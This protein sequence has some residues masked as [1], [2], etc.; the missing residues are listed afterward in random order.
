VKILYLKAGHPDTKLKY[1]DDT[2]SRHYGFPEYVSVAQ[3]RAEAARK[4][5]AL[6]KEK[7]NIQPVLIK[8]RSIAHT[9]WGKSWNQNLERYA[10]YSN[11][12]ERGRSY[13]RHGA[14]LDLQIKPGKI[15]ALVQGSRTRP[16]EVV[17]SIVSLNKAN[18]KR[19]KETTEGQLDSLSE[20]L[21][22][23]FPKPLQE[24]FF[25]EK[26]G[27]FPRPR[28]I[29]F[30]CSCPD[31]ASMCKHVA[32]SLYGVGARL[33][34]DPSL[35]FKLRR[36]K[37]DDLITQ[38]VKSTGQALLKKAE[39][40]SS[41]VLEDTDLTDVFGIKLD[42][43]VDLVQRPSRR[44]AKAKKKI[45]GGRQ[46]QASSVNPSKGKAARSS[47]KTRNKA[48]GKSPSKSIKTPVAPKKSPANPTKTQ[49]IPTKV[50]TSTITDSVVA[51][52]PKRRKTMRVADICAR[53]GLSEQQ[54]RNAVARAIVQG[55]LRKTGRGIY[56]RP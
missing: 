4:L 12:I 27:L 21:A 1:E 51:A 37:M 50:A 55:K 22:G 33:D 2:M 8:G 48:A 56:V 49:A 35:F 16:Y 26:E 3:K 42:E 45:P 10:D 25:A 34:E 53:V 17:I 41:R 20:L 5:Q 19:V 36:I 30:D 54:V 44:T 47:K 18:W 46:Q 15:Q 38:A 40:K 6:R 52:I 29:D 13:V 31:W 28:E 7:P 9:W 43:D 24:L 23:K 14:V 32:A 39:T 11:R